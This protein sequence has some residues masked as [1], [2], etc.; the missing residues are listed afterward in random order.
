ME[1]S[2]H[3]YLTLVRAKVDWVRPSLLM[4]QMVI[5]TG[6]KAQAVIVVTRKVIQWASACIS[7]NRYY[8]GPIP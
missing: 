7:G 2:I 8:D 5:A 1:G 4:C 3:R 6:R